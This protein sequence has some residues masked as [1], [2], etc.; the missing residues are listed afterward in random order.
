M[1]I[2]TICNSNLLSEVLEKKY[3]EFLEKTDKKRD[4]LEQMVNLQNSKK[5]EIIEKIYDG[6]EYSKNREN[7]QHI[8]LKVQEIIEHN[9]NAILELI[10]EL[11]VLNMAV[12]RLVVDMSKND[13]YQT[14]DLSQTVIY[15]KDRVDEFEKKEKIL[16]KVMKKD[17]KLIQN[18]LKDP[19][20]IKVNEGNANS[21]SN[22]ISSENDC[23][24]T[25]I[26]RQNVQNVDKIQR[27]RQGSAYNNQENTEY[28]D[29][30]VDNNVLLI[31]EKE[32]KVYL[33][34]TVDEIE[35]YMEFYPGKYQSLKD[36]IEKEYILP[37]NRFT[38][39]QSMARF[40]ETYDLVRNR[41]FGSMADALRYATKLM[42]RYD[43]NPAI[44]A[45]C[46]KI[47]QLQFY[48][49]CMESKKMDQ[50]DVFEIKFDLN[51]L[52]NV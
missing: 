52:G 10:E 44:I 13:K 27:K 43:L 47:T 48:L 21:Y 33:P 24:S 29:E 4:E 28:A 41:E 14:Q 15:I 22:E 36:I 7:Y 32:K 37:L 11:K 35:K 50:F 30:I 31:S 46:K 6:S 16:N 39:N 25:E 2:D 49:E 42:F 51:L 40:K 23:E 18:Y 26:S 8:I 17:E 19:N 9:S 12:I 45:A 5:N 3:C 1:A 20:L 34:Y 38:K